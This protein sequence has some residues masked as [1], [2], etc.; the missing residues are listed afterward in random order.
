MRKFKNNFKRGDSEKREYGMVI[1]KTLLYEFL[2]CEEEELGELLFEEVRKV[3]DVIFR[4][5]FSAYSGQAEDLK[6]S[7]FTT[8][9]E[10]R[11]GYNPD[12]DAYNYIFTQVRNEIGNNIYRWNRETHI[13]D[14]L[15]VKEEEDN[16]Y[17][18]LNLPSSVIKYQHYLTGEENFTIKRIAKK[19]VLD[20]VLWLRI[21][22]YK[23]YPAP[24]WLIADKKTLG[25]MYKLLKELL[26]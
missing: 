2:L 13:E 6:K 9:L 20:I 23:K 10:R 22:G 24:E 18:T 17:E 26:D 3:I 12:M 25:V 16:S 15:N 7:A 5:Y 8:V 1:N 11:K 14:N 4:K 19:D 21:N